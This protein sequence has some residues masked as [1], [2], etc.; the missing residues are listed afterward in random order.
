M[1]MPSGPSGGTYY[2][3]DDGFVRKYNSDGQLL[4]SRQLGTS[5]YDVHVTEHLTVREMF[6]CAV[7]ILVWEQR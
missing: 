3:L 1:D 6:M 4:W 7:K 5:G 2:G